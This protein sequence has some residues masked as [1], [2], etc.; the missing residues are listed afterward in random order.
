VRSADCFGMTPV[1]CAS[2]PPVSHSPKAQ[3]GRFSPSAI[4]PV[5][6]GALSAM[7][8]SPRAVSQSGRT[9]DR[10]RWNLEGWKN[11]LRISLAVITITGSLATSF[12]QTPLNVL[13]AGTPAVVDSGNPSPVVMGVKVFSDV[14]GQVVGCSFYK[15]PA[16]LGVHVVSLWDA[17]GK[18]L[19]SQAAS[20]ET[21]SGKQSV[22]FSTP[23]AFAAKQVFICGYSS[24]QGHYSATTLTFAAQMDVV[25]L[26]VPASGGLYAY[27]AQSTTMPA[28]AS[29]SN[30]WVVRAVGGFNYL[31]QQRDGEPQR[32]R[33]DRHV[34]Y[35]SSV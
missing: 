33:G 3:S 2:V 19:A 34:E 30:F 20:G 28:N 21:A 11:S 17:T 5:L 10:R 16:N 12:A 9:Q 31:D 26:H 7:R 6:L 35:R 13:G 27:G 15:A 8:L 1:T 24:P 29:T 22:L 14:P 23:V 25:P 18:V 4:S 32:K